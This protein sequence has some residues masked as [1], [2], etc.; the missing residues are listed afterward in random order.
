MHIRQLDDLGSFFSWF[1]RNVPTTAS[2]IYLAGGKEGSAEHFVA[3]VRDRLN[4][5][6]YSIS[7]ERIL[8]DFYIDLWLDKDGGDIHYKR[9]LMRPGNQLEII[10]LLSDDIY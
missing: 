7:A 9:Q 1:R 6:G 10:S 2:S 5:E 8:T 4:K 3:E